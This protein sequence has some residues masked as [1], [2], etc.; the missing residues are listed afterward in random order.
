LSPRRLRGGVIGFSE[1]PQITKP[2][3]IKPPISASPPMQ[4]PLHSENDAMMESNPDL[5]YEFVK[6][7]IIAQAKKDAGELEAYSFG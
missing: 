1:S 5:A 4:I 2:V 6:Q 7:A 3:V